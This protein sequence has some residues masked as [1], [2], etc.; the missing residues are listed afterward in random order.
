PSTPGASIHA[1][2]LGPSYVISFWKNTSVPLSPFQN[3]VLLEVLDEEPVRRHVAA[4]DDDAGVRCVARP[5]HA[6]A[7]VRAPRPD[8]VEDRVTVSTPASTVPPQS[9]SGKL[10][11]ASATQR[12]VFGASSCGSSAG[13][14]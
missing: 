7:V 1:A 3:L 4:V 14:K 12:G 9:R 6:V 13:T 2:W 11:P 10:T 5:P 8:V